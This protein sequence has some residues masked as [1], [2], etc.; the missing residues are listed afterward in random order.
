MGR[1]SVFTPSNDVKYLDGCYRSLDAQTFSD[2]EWVILLNGKAMSWQPPQPDP[3]VKV[4]RA[5]SRVRGVGA[6][7][8][9][10]CEIAS[11]DILV[12]LD[13]DDRLTPD[14]LTEVIAA[15]DAHPDAALVFSDFTQI[16][17]DDSPNDE[18]FD[19]TA[20]WEYVSTTIDGTT[21][22]SCQ[23][24]EAT[25]H[26]VGYI[27]FAPNHVRA[28]RRTAY[29]RAGGYDPSHAILDDQDLMSRLFQ[30]GDFVRIPKCL[31]LQRFHRRNTQRDPT[32]NAEIQQKTIDLYLEYV[33][34]LALCWAQ[35]RGL[36]TFNLRTP[37][38]V[39]E[40]PVDERYTVV[41]LDPAKPVLP[42]EAS[43]AGVIRATDLLP[44]M[45][46]RAAF[47]NEC[48][49]ALA[50]A[51]LLLTDTASTD[52]RGAFQDPSHVAF[53]NENSFS[54]LTRAELR[55]TIPTLT[56][57]LQLSFLQTY[58]PSPVHEDMA[59]PY[60]KA[61]L[62]AIKDGPRQGGQLFV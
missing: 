48:Y 19:A 57:R 23:A 14:C 26:N 50:H 33:E 60:V 61:N 1:I 28:F 8:Q 52:G 16:N 22:L 59:I 11:G 4:E 58:Y 5:R 56:A 62:L 55:P 15:F 46:D 36:A 18:R 51:G 6:A 7:K 9:L 13:H 21:Y 17:E 35:R 37:T 29:D 38:S 27:W 31:Y 41:T 45:P 32:I 24:L 30:V 3:R 34:E 53:Y 47:F 54:Y 12:E 2:W 43:Q 39:N 20:G 40:A 25:P 49:R 42:V 10:A 44:R